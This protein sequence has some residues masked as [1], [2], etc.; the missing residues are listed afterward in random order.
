[1]DSP[2]T[3]WSDRLAFDVAL[4][5][6]NSGDTLDEL[7]KRHRLTP[8]NLLS[9]KKDPVFLRQVDQYRDEIQT[10]GVTFKLKA[11]TQAEELLL[12][13][14]DLIH[15]PEVSA[16]VKADLIKST[17]KWAGLEPKGDFPTENGGG[18]VRITINL[19]GQE[20]TANI[21]EGRANLTTLNNE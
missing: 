10:K 2:G 21:I 18:G 19:A 16:A 1:M 14:W 5:L 6:E 15:H 20:H 11:R 9:Y 17:V 13:S 8:E 3:K 7:L 12:T 4:L